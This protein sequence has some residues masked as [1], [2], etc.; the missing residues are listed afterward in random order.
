[1]RGTPFVKMHGLGNDFVV[2]DARAHA[3]ALEAGVGAVAGVMESASAGRAAK[4]RTKAATAALVVRLRI[5]VRT[6]SRLLSVG[7]PGIGT[8]ARTT[9]PSRLPF[10]G[11]AVILWWRN[12]GKGCAVDRN[13]AGP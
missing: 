12:Q 5:M 8:R 4:A 11:E 10:H 3:I 13:P 6:S 1:M 9:P 2:L 7:G